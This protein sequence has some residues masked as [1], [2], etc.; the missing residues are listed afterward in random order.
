MTDSTDPQG[1]PPSDPAPRSY[2]RQGNASLLVRVVKRT[3]AWSAALVGGLVLALLLAAGVALAVAWPNLPEID[4]LTDYRP[5]L[6]LRVYSKDG[7]L[8]GEFGEERRAFVPI[9]QVP[10]IMKKA[11]LSIEDERFY[12]HG[13]VDVIGIMRAGV[14]NVLKGASAGGASTI[15]QQVARNFYASTE[16]T[17]TRKIYE[18]L[19]AIKIE[20]HLSKDQIFE[21]YLNQ[22]ELGHRSF[23]FAAAAQ[24]YLS[25]IH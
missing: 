19:L 25:L 11:I 13:G 6:P 10:D 14:F 24:R 7:V 17:F 20:G 16:R 2:A 4:T 23:G 3:L 9:A 22:I 5:K 21:V 1:A 18:A 15:T 12:Q 8:L